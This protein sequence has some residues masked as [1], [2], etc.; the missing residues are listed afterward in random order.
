MQIDQGKVFSLIFKEA[1]LKRNSQ[2]NSEQFLCYTNSLCVNKFCMDGN[3][4]HV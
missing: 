3:A 4:I 1:V 2:L